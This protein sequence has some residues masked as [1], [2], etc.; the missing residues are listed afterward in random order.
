MTWTTR[1]A[2]LPRRTGTDAQDMLEFDALYDDQ[3]VYWTYQPWTSKAKVVLDPIVIL[4]PVH[5]IELWNDDT[6][7]GQDWVT[8]NRSRVLMD[9]IAVANKSTNTT[10]TTNPD[11]VTYL[12]QGFGREE[13]VG[14]LQPD[15][16]WSQ[17]N[18]QFRLVNYSSCEVDA[19][20]LADTEPPAVCSDFRVLGRSNAAIGAVSNCL[21]AD[22]KNGVQII[23]TG[24]LEG[25]GCPTIGGYTERN[26]NAAVIDTDGLNDGARTWAHELGHVFGLRHVTA[27]G[28]EDRLMFSPATGGTTLTPNECATAR[29]RAQ[30]KQSEW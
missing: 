16:I 13:L 10:P 6:S 19:K 25:Q 22:K 17:C 8:F 28:S 7:W 23:M 9:D 3:S 11:S 26:S 21:Q 29:D 24:Q 4:V 18:I 1:G 5:V 20:I 15:T 2:L 27:S 12:W 30:A 14:H